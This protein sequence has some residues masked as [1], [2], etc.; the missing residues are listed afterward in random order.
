MPGTLPSSL[1]TLMPSIALAGVLPVSPCMTQK[2]P[3][4]TSALMAIHAARLPLEVKPWQC[5]LIVTPPPTHDP[6]PTSFVSAYQAIALMTAT[7]NASMMNAATRRPTTFVG[8]CITPSC[9]S[10]GLLAAP[11]YASGGLHASNRVRHAHL[12]G[13]KARLPAELLLQA[14][15]ARA[16]R[17]GDRG[18][19]VTTRREPCEPGRYPP[20]R[21]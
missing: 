11:A 14:R 10:V 7:I 15:V 20:R 9:P 13:R 19:G 21:P 4:P 17:S 18:H 3:I 12:G 5:P 6:R 8:C 2:I 16:R 1:M